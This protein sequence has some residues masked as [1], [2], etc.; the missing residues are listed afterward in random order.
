MMDNTPSGAKKD[1]KSTELESRQTAKMFVSSSSPPPPPPPSSSSSFYRFEVSQGYSNC[2]LK[3]YGFLSD[4]IFLHVYTC[5]Q[6]T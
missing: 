4:A 2:S 3:N 1:R 6:I 5:T